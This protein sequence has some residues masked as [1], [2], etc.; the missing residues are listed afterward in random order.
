MVRIQDHLAK[1]SW[2]AADKGLFLVYGFVNI[3]QNNALPPQELGLYTLCNALQTFIFAV[4][5]GFVLQS[6]IIFGTDKELRGSIN[7]FAITWHVIIT[8]GASALV[9]L[10][11]LPFAWLLGEPR[12]SAVAAYL[13]IF[14][15]L[16]IPRTLCLKYL[17]RD[18]QARAIFT[19]NIVWISTM[20]ALTA[21]MLATKRL[22]S[23][24][25]M[26]L[27][28]ASGMAASSLTALWITRKQLSFKGT[29]NMTQREFFR[30]GAYQGTAS[31]LGNTVRQLDV[32]VV[33]F[34]FGTA[35]VGVYQSAKTL[36]RFFDEGFGAITSLVYPATVRLVHEERQTELV[37]LLSKM[38]SFSLFATLA[39]VLLT[40]LNIAEY[41]ISRLLS[42][43]YAA[44]IGYFR[45]LSFAAPAMPFVAL[46]P[47]MLA[48]GEMR[49]LL[50]FIIAAVVAGLTALACVGYLQ[51]SAFAPLGFVFYTVTLGLLVFS[52]VRSRLHF[53]LRLLWR[54]V[55]DTLDYFGLIKSK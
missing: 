51:L 28:A 25:A 34:F 5:D 46:L 39:V 24:E 29:K 13:P 37:A 14:C 40:E 7:R 17:T 35:T 2:T 26:F 50:L 18:V 27:I 55:P 30:A 41:V 21:W 49:R 10:L 38:V 4:S 33:Q 32:T 22:V 9:F 23:F 43:K 42:P 15:L 8:L 44:A 53:P 6:I 48:F 47:V 36:F 12:L 45:L 54:A 20:C 1:I 52:F 3:M 19:V 31:M 16:G 11:Q